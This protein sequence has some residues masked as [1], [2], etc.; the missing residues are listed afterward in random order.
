MKNKNINHNYWMRIC[1]DIAK[2]STCRVQIACVILKRNVIV[3]VGYNGSISGDYHCSDHCCLFMENPVAGSGTS[4][5]SCIR[6]VHAEM[7]AVLKCTVR[8]SQHDGWLKAYCT[9]QPCV[10]CFKALMQ[11]GVR[12]IV[13]R[14]PY[15]D[16]WRDELIKYM[17]N[18]ILVDEGFVMEK[19]EDGE[20]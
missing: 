13:Y 16:L 7:N 17:S 14:K 3:G 5:K 19:L 10:N 1:D 9:Y 15:K 4:G 18:E 6:T 20:N 8:G 12:H 11:I 2:A